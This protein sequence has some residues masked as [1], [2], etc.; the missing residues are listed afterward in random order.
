[1]QVDVVGTLQPSPTG[2]GSIATLTMSQAIAGVFSCEAS[3]FDI[4][5]RVSTGMHDYEYECS[6]TVILCTNT[7]L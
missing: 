3:D 1:M 4:S 5:L 7:F 2:N 6:R